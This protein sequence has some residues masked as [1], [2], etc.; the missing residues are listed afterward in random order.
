MVGSEGC[1]H[2]SVI[3]SV[4]SRCEKARWRFSC[5]NRGW[6]FWEEETD[7]QGLWECFY[8]LPAATL[9]LFISIFRAKWECLSLMEKFRSMAR[10]Y[11]L[12]RSKPPPNYCTAVQALYQSKWESDWWTTSKSEL[13][14]FKFTSRWPPLAHLLSLHIL[15]SVRFST[16]HPLCKQGYDGAITVLWAVSSVEVCSIASGMKTL[17]EL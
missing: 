3:S 9:P 7:R 15:S 8:L 17:L 2:D 14:R 11:F 4:S 1:C 13:K 10:L 6:S 5:G 16:E 12:L